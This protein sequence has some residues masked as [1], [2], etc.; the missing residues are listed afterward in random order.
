MWTWQ[1]KGYMDDSLGVEWFDTILLMQ[2]GPERPQLILLDNHHS[3]ETL[4]LLELAKKHDDHIHAFPAHTTSC[5]CPL[6]KTVFG[7]LK[8]AYN[9]HTSAFVNES[10]LHILNKS[11]WS[12]QFKHAYTDAIT[13]SN[14]ISGFRACGIMPWNP[15]IISPSDLSPSAQ[16]DTHSDL[17]SD[18]DAHPLL[19]VIREVS[20]MADTHTPEADAEIENM[21]P[22]PSTSTNVTS[23]VMLSSSPTQVTTLVDNTEH[24]NT[25]SLS[26]GQTI[27]V[28]LPG[29]KEPQLF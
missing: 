1:K 25:V 3:H 20:K 8:A 15:L 18:G 21:D 19:W 17:A 4:D 16:F 14:I 5:L 2:C 27:L 13:P 29:S 24:I 23:D 26:E 28:K 10:P 9:R 11:T 22:G 6:D 7:P 12:K